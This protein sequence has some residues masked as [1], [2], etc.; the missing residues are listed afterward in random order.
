[1]GED[2]KI[3]GEL[4]PGVLIIGDKEK[5][6]L[7]Q[8]KEYA[9]SNIISMRDTFSGI[10]VGSKPPH[11]AIIPADFRVVFSLHNQPKPIHLIR[12]V[13][14]SVSRD[15][16]IPIPEAIEMIADE[17]GF[18]NSIVETIAAMSKANTDMGIE[19]M[20]GNATMWT[21]EFSDN[22]QA[23]NFMEK[24]DITIQ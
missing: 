9:E 22:R 11:V 8:L 5:R 1:M 4:P 12:Q 13:S 10:P 23:I 3:I 18:R 6:V 17:L 24:V 21:E 19:L 15:K 14:V 16:R 20:K 2:F 7:K